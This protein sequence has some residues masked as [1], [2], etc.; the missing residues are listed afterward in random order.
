M[1]WTN[2]IP[3]LFHQRLVRYGSRV[4]LR[5]KTLGRW[6]E[7][8]WRQYGQHV[9]EVAAGLIALGLRRGDC[10]SIIAE[11]RPEWLYSDL[12][13][14][15]AGGVTVGVYTTSSPEQCEYILNHCGSRFHIVEDEEQLD[16]VLR[17]R[18]R[19]PLLEQIMVI[20]LKGL[21]RFQ[22]PKVISF[23]QLLA[24]GRKLEAIQPGL[25]QRSLE[26]GKPEDIAILVYTSGTTGPPKG[27]MLSHETVL[28]SASLLEQIG[29]IGEMDETISYLPLAHIAQRLLTTFGQ[30]RYGYTVNFAENLDT[31]PHDLRE[32]SPHIFFGPPRIWE[33]CYSAITLR[34]EHATRLKRT[35]YR[36]ALTIGK[37]EAKR[38]LGGLA[39][40]LSLRLAS[41]LA[42]LAVFRK[43]KAHL[44]L[45]RSRYV[46]SGAAPISPGLLGFFQSIGV[47]VKESY[48]QTESCGPATAHL[49]DRI[50]LGTVG[51]AIPGCEVRIA[52]DGEI[53]LR[54]RN[55]FQGYFKD[56]QASKE[57]LRD[58]WLCTGDMGELDSEGFLALTDRKKD[59]IITSGGKNVAPQLIENLLKSS[60][61]VADAVVIGDRRKY[62]SALIVIDQETVASFAQEHR[63]PFTTFS[64]LTT[65][66]DVHALIGR[67]VER[68]NT[69]LS[70][71]EKI[72]RFAILDKTLDP[73]DGDVTPTMKVK[74]KA[75]CQ[76]YN[77]VIES[78]YE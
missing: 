5:K 15:T 1:V 18:D 19:L 32:V 21:R 39:V 37:H 48:G 55:V 74:R 75:I 60:P 59:L 11:N 12:G 31:F 78:M 41:R 47:P 58:G 63:I 42:H 46:L 68:V 56:P 62:L 76:R 29:P 43:L 66:S 71:P 40:P 2:T 35:V 20:D 70:Q 45:D 23:D 73:D 51:Q 77:K 36:A 65:K 38:R 44:G 25:V 54:G 28:F 34:M 7:T 33:K 72:K 13:I 27:A 24:A 14:I 30:I 64:D 49:G 57:V 9:R 67:E 16:K 52:E 22:D 3:L 50:K 69:A 53:L 61:Y 26:A 8:S 6:Q 4:A 17:I 10:V